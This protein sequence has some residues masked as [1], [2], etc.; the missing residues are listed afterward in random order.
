MAAPRPRAAASDEAPVIDCST[1][2][3]R[4]GPSNLK[5]AFQIETTPHIG[6]AVCSGLGG[7]RPALRLLPYLRLSDPLYRVM[8]A[9]QPAGF[10]GQ[11]LRRLLDLL[12]S[13][14]LVP[15][16]GS[17]AGIGGALG[18]S[19]LLMVATLPRKRVI[20]ALQGDE[21]EAVIARLRPARDRLVHLAERDVEAYARV[22][23]ARRLPKD[24]PAQHLARHIA[25]QQALRGATDVP[26]EMM[27]I[28]EEALRH[29]IVISRHSLASARSDCAI[30]IE[31][32]SV[33]LR[34]A[35]RAVDANLSRFQDQVYVSRVTKQCRRFESDATETMKS[36]LR[37]LDAV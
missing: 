8:S 32:I 20:P 6:P 25:L 3:S 31:L 16:G 9:V 21:L 15:G 12:A 23:D 13:G 35:A 19:L 14:L 11:T 5:Y 24:S 27:R 7:A 34:G 29:G 10:S 1:R 30:G 28:C 17:A 33:A 36:I 37:A 26:L 18:V 2:T 22:I 4:P